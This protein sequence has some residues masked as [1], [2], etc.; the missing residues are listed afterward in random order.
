[1]IIPIATIDRIY[2]MEHGRRRDVAIVGI[3]N[4]DVHGKKLLVLNADTYT[5]TTLIKAVEHLEWDHPKIIKTGCLILYKG[6]KPGFQ[7]DFFGEKLALRKADRPL[8]WRGTEYPFDTEEDV[9]L[10]KR[11]LVVLHGLVA[12]GKTSVTRAI[13]KGLGHTPIYSD[14][15]WFKY[16]LRD[17]HLN[18][19]VSVHH[20][21]HMLALCLSAIGTGYDA[22]LDCTSRWGAFRNDCQNRLAQYSVQVVF[23]RCYCT[24][25]S[26]IDRIN[27]RQFIGPYDFGTEFEYSR[28][29]KEY[30]EI[31]TEET[32]Q[33]NLVEVDTDALICKI[34]N[35]VGDEELRQKMKSIRHAIEDHY[36]SK[37]TK[38]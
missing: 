36:F 29:K 14:W 11:V 7:P 1:R 15:Y 9:A 27:R 30:Q 32:A 21:N 38:S 10:S 34:V 37:L 5:G 4:L 28:V 13:S 3:H 20:N 12:T 31:N 25:S 22:V 33:I 16:G 18:T 2:L 35:C 8:P 23:V 17:R 24:E 19:N 6:R 26:S